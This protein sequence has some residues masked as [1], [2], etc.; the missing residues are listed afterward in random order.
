MNLNKKE[1]NKKK[2][3]YIYIYIFDKDVKRKI[4]QTMWL[5]I[6]N[7]AKQKCV[8]A[9]KIRVHNHTWLEALDSG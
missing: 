4:N 2:N 8:L 9:L 1:M 3:I 7:L 6:P 5:F